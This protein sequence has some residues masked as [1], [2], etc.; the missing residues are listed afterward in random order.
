MNL[1]TL[2]GLRLQN[3]DF[4]RPKPLLL[5]GYLA[6]EGARDRRHVAELFF[7]QAADPMNSLRT[8]LKRLRQDAPG[9]LG[10]KGD[11]L[12]AVVEC[13][14][15]VLLAQ[16]E[17]GNLETAVNCYEGAFLAG[18]KLP[19]W[20]VEL[21]EWVYATR[22]FIASR[23]RGALL[24]LA[25]RG[26]TQ[27]NFSLAAML[28]ERA[29]W[30]AGAPDPEPEEFVR[31]GVLFTAGQSS[32]VGR[33]RSQAQDFEIE[34]NF[35]LDQ[36]RAKLL[37]ATPQT[38]RQNLPTR[39]T[40]FIGR[41]IERFQVGQALTR[42]D[43]RLLTLVGPGGVGKTRLAL[44]IAR[45][46][47]FRDGTVFVSLEAMTSLSFLPNALANALGLTLGD[48]RELD[49]ALIKLLAQQSLL[50]VLDSVEHLLEGAAYLPKLL[51][52]CPNL[53]FLVTSR[54]RL[55]LEEEWVFPLGG[56]AVPKSDATL[57]AAIVFE[58]VQL[59]VGRAKRA[60]LSFNLTPS[61]LSAALQICELVGG[62]PLGIEL[63]AAWVKLMSV[64]EIAEEINNN[65]DFLTAA[66][67]DAPPRHHSV[68]AV[69]E[70]TWAR[71]NT[72]ERQALSKLSVFRGGFS[73]EA[74][75]EIAGTSLVTL[76]SLADKSLLHVAENG[77]YDLHV[78]LRQYA[79]EALIE[80]LGDLKVTQIAHGNFFFSLS[81]RSYDGFY[82]MQDEKL[83]VDRLNVELENIRTALNWW[84]ERGEVETALRCTNFLRNYWSRTGQAR[85][86]QSWL[87]RGLHLATDIDAPVR[88]R[89][90][91]LSGQLA[92]DMGDYVEAQQLLEEALTLSQTRG[93]SAP[94][95]LLH[96]GFTAQ[97]IG[98]FQTAR[99]RFEQALT[100][101]RE[102][103][104]LHGIASSLNNLG[105]ILVATNDLPGALLVYEEALRYKLEAGGDV[106]GLLA[107]LSELY[108]HLGD[109]KTARTYSIRALKGLSERAFKADIPSVLENL[110]FL[111]SDQGQSH[112]A[113]VLLG[114]ATLQREATNIPKH[115]IY[116]DK[117]EHCIT[118][119]RQNLS[120]K[121]FAIA[122]DEGRAMTLEQAVAYAI[123]SEE[124]SKGQT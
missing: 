23:V 82:K 34:L 118:I 52:E 10:A 80:N 25:E 79:H 50:V 53:K 13:D 11:T 29:C 16:L 66:N 31:L 75:N 74:A 21:E 84:L 36:A 8:T 72:T 61:D 119:A 65:L 20:S 76:S 43:V 47:L 115:P 46:S 62:S 42:E 56:L 18:L 112:Q 102:A 28:A 30:L 39:G 49:Q 114:A 51:Q 1:Q 55:G 35:T 92:Y 45:E 106:D 105:S 5:L 111:A 38:S 58:S 4:T 6:L 17:A 103:N 109:Y 87:S 33:L 88:E 95:T 99:E 7:S 3:S 107:N 122:W 78:L 69:F 60:R 71:L 120:E 73:R 123:H 24:T 83:W 91:A 116:C 77:R 15:Q 89:A 85:E 40:S 27:A 2:G 19:D 67:R 64:S 94:L 44:E 14:A 124:S 63:A 32:M 41:T 59:F 117:F 54:E 110:G 57:Q 113:C 9:A 86:G 12:E 93:V 98:D 101:F 121:Q 26:A 68:R 90:L 97:A 70:Q 104:I 108:Y 22:E 100:L 37:G 48:D 96:L 81:Q